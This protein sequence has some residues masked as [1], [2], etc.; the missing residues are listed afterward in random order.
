MALRFTQR[1]FLGLREEMIRFMSEKLGSKWNDYSE[2]DETMTLIEL[3]AHCVSNLHFAYDNQKRETDIVTASFPRNV[4]AHA[5][6]NGYKP[7]LFRAGKTWLN[8]DLRKKVDGEVSEE[9]AVL[10]VSIIIPRYTQIKNQEGDICITNQE[11]VLPAGTSHFSIEVLAGEYAFEQFTRT[12]INEFNYIPLS[13]L[14]IAY[15][16]TRL[17]YKDEEWTPVVDVYTDART[18]KI[19]SLEPNFIQSGVRNIIRFFTTWS[20]EITDSEALTLEYIQTFG[21]N[22]NYEKDTFTSYL[23]AGNYSNNTVSFDDDVFDSTGN[24]IDSWTDI[25][26][27]FTQSKPFAY[28]QNF[29]AIEVIK[30]SYLQSIRQTTSLVVLEDYYAFITLFGLVDFYVTDWNKNKDEYITIEYPRDIKALKA[31]EDSEGHSIYSP[32]NTTT[33]PYWT[34]NVS[35]INNSDSIT[36]TR[37]IDGR[38]IIIFKSFDADINDF[39]RFANE[40]WYNE[41]IRASFLM[42]GNNSFSTF[43]P[44]IYLSA[45]DRI[46]NIT[47]IETKELNPVQ[48]QMY[49]PKNILEDNNC[50][51]P[52]SYG[53]KEFFGNYD[54]NIRFLNTNSRLRRIT[55]ELIAN[56]DVPSVRNFTWKT[57]VIGYG[58]DSEKSN[59]NKTLCISYYDLDDAYSKN[60]Y[61]TTKDF[62]KRLFNSYLKQN[63]VT[64]IPFKYPPSFYNQTEI[65][66]TNT[67]DVLFNSNIDEIYSRK[68][69]NHTLTQFKEDLNSYYGSDFVE[70]SLSKQSLI[71]NSLANKINTIT[72]KIDGIE[73]TFTVPASLYYDTFC[74]L[75]GESLTTDF[76]ESQD[77]KDKTI[78]KPFMFK[79]GDFISPE[80]IY[81][82]ISVPSAD[83]ID[84]YIKDSHENDKNGLPI[85]TL[86]K[87]KVD[88]A[89]DTNPTPVYQKICLCFRKKAIDIIPVVGMTESFITSTNQVTLNNGSIIEDENNKIYIPTTTDLTDD[90]NLFKLK[91]IIPNYYITAE[92]S[93]EAI[94]FENDKPIVVIGDNY[95]HDDF[96]LDRTQ[97]TVKPLNIHYYA[98]LL[99]QSED[100]SSDE[101]D[102]L[103]IE[104]YL[105][106]DYENYY[107]ESN[108]LFTIYSGDTDPIEHQT[109][110]FGFLRTGRTI[111]G[112]HKYDYKEKSFDADIENIDT[113][114]IRRNNHIKNS[115]LIDVQTNYPKYLKFLILRVCFVNKADFMMTHK[116]LNEMLVELGVENIVYALNKILTAK[117]SISYWYSDTSSSIGKQYT[118]SPNENKRFLACGGGSSW[119]DSSSPGKNYFRW[120]VVYPE[121]VNLYQ[122]IQQKQGRGDSVMIL[123]YTRNPLDIHAHIYILDSTPDISSVFEN[124]WNSLVDWLGILK[125]IEDIKY[126]SEFVSVMQAAD[127]NILKVCGVNEIMYSGS[128]S[129]LTPSSSPEDSIYSVDVE[130]STIKDFYKFLTFEPSKD[131]LPETNLGQSLVLGTVCIRLQKTSAYET[132][133]FQFERSG[134][135]PGKTLAYKLRQQN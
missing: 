132:T 103:Y 13:R 87:S 125:N 57:K 116:E 93:E 113:D 84:S 56:A 45:P 123:P 49:S 3:L 63:E 8:I 104:E 81:S 16:T 48:R 2:S 130:A 33:E 78:I 88:L 50:T 99:N 29:E 91:T 55:E 26:F 66:L 38:E 110:D 133:V 72:L 101:T 32:A 1:D 95:Y 74:V 135:N 129:L 120:D 54:N 85:L 27:G 65:T 7:S 34:S 60:G 102:V 105:V 121:I 12:D 46:K 68:E 39:S 75:D 107:K 52:E 83:D 64:T 106:K 82:T 92:Q 76:I 122:S 89:N 21:A 117:V 59:Y 17:H 37:K 9:F 96:I 31:E 61:N 114:I 69:E 86:Y 30:K 14:N 41:W 40:H 67:A 24:K 90:S 5:I 20:D 18:S 77:E 35:F 19:Y 70:N 111:K 109:G 23:E 6:R 58:I 100:V 80:N 22:S 62:Q 11:Y 119:D 36:T 43:S 28:G 128:Y 25:D 98:E 79:H 118:Y 15:G 44:S 124:I 71:K 126:V 97:L 115:F 108:G 127:G 53:C 73:E 131:V 134:L 112:L 4:Y 47:D 42:N 94:I 10:P 51:D